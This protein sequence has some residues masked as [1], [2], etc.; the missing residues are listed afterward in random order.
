MPWSP[1]H[2]K[3]LQHGCRD[4]AAGAAPQHS[5]VRDGGEL[6]CAETRRPRREVE[7]RQLALGRGVPMAASSLGSIHG[8]PCG[9]G[10]TEGTGVSSAHRTNSPFPTC[11]AGEGVLEVQQF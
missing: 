3:H 10:E 9:G 1:R 6:G 5:T 11:M 2:H 8:L 7:H 4:I